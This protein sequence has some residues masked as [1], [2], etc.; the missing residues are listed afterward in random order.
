MNRSSRSSLLFF[1]LF[2]MVQ[3]QQKPT[4]KL[5]PPSNP[6]VPTVNCT[7]AQ[8]SKA[9]GSFKQLLNAHD[10]DVQ[11]ILSSP[12]S[13]VCFRPKD[14]AFLVFH[15][16]APGK[17]GWQNSDDGG[18]AP[19]WKSTVT[20]I[21]Y[22][23]GVFYSS[24]ISRDYWRRFSPTDAPIFHSE[25]KD[26]RLAGLT[27]SIDATEIYVD[28][29]FKNQNGGTTQ[30]SLTIRRSTGRFVETFA[31]DGTSPTTDSGSCIIYR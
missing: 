31:G 10:K 12:T 11:D 7:D 30:Y 3:A 5:P 6:K 27:I 28:Y 24:K 1:A 21:E 9:C 23:D 26:G 25:T 18:E 16:E 19:I 29:P 20:L 14:D 22:R 17:E 8:T 15:S 2:S 4:G 13:Y